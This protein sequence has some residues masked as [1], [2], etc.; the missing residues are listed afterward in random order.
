MDKNNLYSKFQAGFR[1]DYRTT[2]HLYAIQ[3]ILNIYIKI[4]KQFMHALL[5]LQ[6]FD[7]V[8]RS[9]LY[10]KILQLG[11]DGNIY[12]VVKYMYTNSKFAVKKNNVMSKFGGD[13]KKCVRQGDGLSPLLFNVYINDFGQIF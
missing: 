6:A 8:W 12:S 9:G 2:D 13:Y 11:I 5:F 4:R 1:P 10:Q 3:T 7:A